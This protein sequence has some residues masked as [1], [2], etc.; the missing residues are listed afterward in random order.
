M[1]S[2]S[3]TLT[4]TLEGLDGS[5]SQGYATITLVKTNGFMPRVSGAV[6]VSPL[7]YKA[8]CNGS[9]VFSVTLWGNDQIT[10]SGTK[11]VIT[12]YS[13]DGSAG[14]PVV[15]SLTGSGGDISSI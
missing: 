13:A 8:L 3:Y 4:G 1:A 6:L 15:K 9:G 5:A 10:P 14:N 7:T 11:Y 12:C 2:P